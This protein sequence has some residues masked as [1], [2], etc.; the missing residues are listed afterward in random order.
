MGVPAFWLRLSRGRRVLLLAVLLLGVLLAVAR[1]AFAPV[2]EEER[3][4]AGVLE[5]IQAAENESV[6]ELA[7]TISRNYRG[8]YGTDFDDLMARAERDF[9]LISNL[10]IRPK[11]WTI[12]IEGDRAVVDLRFTF[13]LVIEK[14]SGYSNIPMSRLPTTPQGEDDKARLVLERDGEHWRIVEIEVAIPGH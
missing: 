4:K 8:F 7:A 3:V 6:A 14:M 9:G 12:T 2:S 10:N 1:L 5:S 11:Q 13:R